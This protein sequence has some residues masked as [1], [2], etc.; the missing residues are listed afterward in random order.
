MREATLLQGK[1]VSGEAV[2]R[3]F[4]EDFEPIYELVA[5]E[6]YTLLIDKIT[7]EFDKGIV[8]IRYLCYLFFA[9]WFL[10]Q[11]SENYRVYLKAFS[12]SLESLLAK[13]DEGEIKHS[14]ILSALN[15][16]HKQLFQHIDYTKT[17]I[18]LLAEDKNELIEALMSYKSLVMELMT[19]ESLS[20]LDRVIDH[21]KSVPPK[22]VSPEKDSSQEDK[23]TKRETADKTNNSTALSHS[24]E[25][26][27]NHKWQ[28][29]LE[30]LK[31]YNQLISS[32]KWLL[33]AIIQIKLDEEIANFNPVEYF[34][35]IFYDYL[36]ANARSY[37]KIND[38]QVNANHPLWKLMER[39]YE[40]DA[41]TFIHEEQA[42]FTSMMQ[43]SA[44]SSSSNQEGYSNQTNGYDNYNDEYQQNDYE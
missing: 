25:A 27:G 43:Q 2:Y 29:L 38:Q 15:W 40:A 1:I 42:F 5:K 19:E 16:L 41:G 31:R 4:T 30:N 44:H 14:H 9:H 17:A 36:Q 6:D 12:E 3:A 39:M 28:K 13:C 35:H 24:A 22:K 10:N 32:E 7:L 20:A 34:P 26:L 23:S 18:S 37:H 8:D 21:W 33:A 11:A